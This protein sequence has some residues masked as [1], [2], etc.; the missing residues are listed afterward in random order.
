MYLTPQEESLVHMVSSSIKISL[1]KLL[2]RHWKL[3]IYLVI[4]GIELSIIHNLSDLP[5]SIGN[6]ISKAEQIVSFKVPSDNFYGPGAAILLTPF[7]W[8]KNELFFV[9]LFYFLLGTIAYWKIVSEIKNRFGQRVAL[10]AL[11][12]NIYLLWLINSSQDTVFEYCLL[13]WSVYFLTKIK[14][15]SFSTCAYLLSLT[16]AGYWTF[17]LGTTI[18]LILLDIIKTNRIQFKKAIAIPLLIFTSLFNYANFGSPS[19]ALEGESLHTLVIQSITIWPYQ[20]WIW[21]CSYLGQKGFFPPN[22]GQTL[23]NIKMVQRRILNFKKLRLMLRL[24]IRERHYL[25][26]C[27]K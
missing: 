27:R 7:L 5:V 8:I 13:L 17:F 9:I 10:M 25:D 22:M 18:L 6:W 14:Y 16:R 23:T 26:G 11:P 3:V 4:L 19:P 21:M 20:K 24:K 12:L 15:L 2:H 1:K